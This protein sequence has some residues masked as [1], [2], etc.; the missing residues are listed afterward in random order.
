MKKLRK[1]A[2][3][4]PQEKRAREELKAR[5][6]LRMLNKYKNSQESY[7]FHKSGDESVKDLSKS[8]SFGLTFIFSFFMAGLTGFYFGNYFLNFD[9]AK[10]SFSLCS[11]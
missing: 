3:Q 7:Y 6:E 2:D 8:I 11:P 10:V 5:H 1:L 4:T 9:Q